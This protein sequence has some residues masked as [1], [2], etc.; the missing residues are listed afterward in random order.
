[1]REE[2]FYDRLLGLPLFQGMSGYDLDEVVAHTKFGFH[3]T[4]PG[5]TIL[6]EGDACDAL[7][8]LLRGRL[9]ARIEADDHGYAFEEEEDGPCILQPE[10]LFGLTQRYTRTY[11]TASPCQLLTIDKQEVLRLTERFG[12]FRLNL[13]NIISTQSQK[14]SRLPWHVSSNTRQRII[15]FFE[16]RC[17]RPSGR[18]VIRIKIT[19]LAAE[20]HVGKQAI[21][22]EMNRMRDEHLLTFSRGIVHIP[23]LEQLLSASPQ[24]RGAEEK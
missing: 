12:I 21:S 17:N 20:L 3:K 19:R 11:T 18:K 6:R 8:F 5:K 16:T 13:I 1:M 10:R 22:E 14:M 4:G 7:C 2:R 24:S 23:A 15:Q 9:I